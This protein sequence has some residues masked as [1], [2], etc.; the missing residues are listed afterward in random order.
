MW[1]I[2][3]ASSG[4]PAWSAD[5]L[6]PTVWIVAPPLL[7]RQPRWPYHALLLGL[8][9]DLL[10]EPVVGP[11]GIAWSAA[12]LAVSALAGLVAH[13]SARAW[14]G[15]GAAAVLTVFAIRYIACLPLRL[16]T[17]PS[18]EHLVRSIVFTAL[19]C[20]LVGWLIGLDLPTRW[21]RYRARRLH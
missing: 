14:A 9:W 16:A 18:V 1:T 6:L 7:H 5:I 11:G 19:W 8:G 20:G 4:L 13:R 17:M 3:P 10:L 15:F 2:S 12:A 21:Q